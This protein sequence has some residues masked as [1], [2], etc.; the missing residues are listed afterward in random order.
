MNKGWFEHFKW[1]IETY[2]KKLQHD[3]A[4]QNEKQASQKIKEVL[5]LMK[6]CIETNLENIEEGEQ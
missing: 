1:E 6:E 5:R 2:M 3:A 4:D